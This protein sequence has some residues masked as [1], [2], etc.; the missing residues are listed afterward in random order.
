[1]TTIR[2]ATTADAGPIVALMKAAYDPKVLDVTIYGCDGIA[3]YLTA[4]LTLPPSLADTH[5]LVADNDGVLMGFTELRQV[6]TTIFV[7]Y[8]CTAADSRGAGIAQA[9]LRD[10]I[11]MVQRVNHASVSLDVFH[12]NTHARQWYRR[13]GFVPVGQ[14]AWWGIHLAPVGAVPGCLSAYAQAEACQ[15]AY[16]F[17]SFT[18]ATSAGNYT[19]GKLGTQWFR[20]NDATLLH[21]E[22]ALASLMV[23]DPNRQLLA[24]LPLEQP[25]AH[26]HAAI[27]HFSERLSIE[28]G[29]LFAR[30]GS[31]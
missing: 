27:L 5:Y 28:I 7:N 12:D 31:H 26:H 23:L 4:Q 17:S 22:E 25:Y 16:G 20:T 30:F 10:G 1:M 8:I 29:A 14:T 2:F 24:L 13:L 11:R 15:R 6:G 18:V 9:M 19:I 3:Q 21:D